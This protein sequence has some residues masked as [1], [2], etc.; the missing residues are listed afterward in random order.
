MNKYIDADR[1]KAE[2]TGWRN[3]QMGFA[4]DAVNEVLNIIDSLQQE[5]PEVD[6]EEEISRTYRDGSVTDTSDM[7]HVS[8]E[9][10]AHHFYSLGINARK[11]ESK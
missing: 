2:I 6:L 1:L 10:I 3:K 5:Q 9:N 4:W 8:Y 11:E 7:D